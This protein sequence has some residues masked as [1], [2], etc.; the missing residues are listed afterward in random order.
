MGRR[1]RSFGGANAHCQR[2]FNVF[3]DSVIHDFF[4]PRYSLPKAI[5]AHQNY[6]YWGPREYTGESVILLGWSLEDAQYWCG[7]VEKGPENAPY[8][9]MGWERYT[10]LVCRDFKIPLYQAWP[11]LK[12]WN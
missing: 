9:G 8:Y 1:D 7:T 3:I 4:G 10:I 2:S 11:R 5:S 12:T 6:Y